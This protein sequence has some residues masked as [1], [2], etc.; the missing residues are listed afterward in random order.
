[1]MFRNMLAYMQG[2][3]AKAEK[4]LTGREGM[5]LL[6]IIR[7]NGGDV[8]SSSKGGDRYP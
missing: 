3:A 6:D 1:M 2:D 4:G 5:L 7:N 8:R